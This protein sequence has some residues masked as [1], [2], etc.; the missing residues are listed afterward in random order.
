MAINR[1]NTETQEQNFRFLTNQSSIL[2]TVETNDINVNGVNVIVDKPKRGDVMCISN[3]KVVW[4]DGL[5]INPKQLSQEYEPVGICLVVNGNKALVRYREEQPH[6]FMGADR[7]LVDVRTLYNYDLM[8]LDFSLND[9]LVASDQVFNYND[10]QDSVSFANRL[11]EIFLVKNIPCFAESTDTTGWNYSD[12]GLVA[13]N[14][15]YTSQFGTK[16]TISLRIHNTSGFNLTP[17]LTRIYFNNSNITNHV[18]YCYR[19]NGFTANR[20][21]CCKAKAYDYTQLDQIA[22]TAAMT[23]INNVPGGRWGG[24]W[25]VR[26]VDFNENVNCAILRE[27]FTNYDEYLD[28]MMVKYPCG[29][30]GAVTES[31]SGKKDT[32]ELSKYTYY[33]YEEMI[34]EPLYPAAY[35]ASSISLDAP[36]LDK[37]NWWLPSVAEM[38]QMMS[39]ITYGTSFWDTNPDIINRVLAKLTSI[40]NSNWS[41]LS[42]ST[43]RWTSYMYNKNLAYLYYCNYGYMFFCNL[44][45]TFL[46]TPITIYEFE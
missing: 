2:R 34:E 11:N 20:T 30:G 44:S 16:N 1:V 8:Y 45:D 5:S 15:K 17:T 27:N 6:R 37:G 18:D 10:L 28:S 36:K 40:S 29:A 32:Y 23:S 35:W 46:A 43:N 24:Q 33:N 12:N 21:I 39:D 13:I 3:H 31:P 42:A 19:K 9:N 22:P 4:I 14:C 41:M 38:A 26:L 25:P 7:F